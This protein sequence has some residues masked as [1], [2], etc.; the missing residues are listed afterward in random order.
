LRIS[1]FFSVTDALEAGAAAVLASTA[2]APGSE[3]TM[4]TPSATIDV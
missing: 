1:E 4:S 2:I 3:P